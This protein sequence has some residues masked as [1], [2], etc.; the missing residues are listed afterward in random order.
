MAEVSSQWSRDTGLALNFIV[1]GDE[2]NLDQAVK[3]QLLQVAREAL[4][5]V[6]KHAYP[7]NVWV[8]LNYSNGHIQ[9]TV[10]DDGRGFASTELRG[11]GM[12]IMSERADMAGADLRIESSPGNGTTVIIE[13][14]NEPG[15]TRTNREYPNEP[16][17]ISS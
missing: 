5:N 11:H 6:A 13:Y 8:S 9:I 16:E 17:R 4:A 1:S 7:E 10:K 12:G 14:P 15:N 3:F 2:G